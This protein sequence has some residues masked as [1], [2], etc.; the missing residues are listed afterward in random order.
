MTADA[1]PTATYRLQFGPQF[2]FADAAA[3]VPYL[4]ELGISHIYASPYLKARRGST[5]G[6]DIVDHGALNPQIG[7][8]SD[9]D[10]LV[11]QLH[12]HDMGQILD[13]VPNHMGVGGNDNAWWL[14]VL[15]NG[16][17]SP[18]AAYFDID[19]SPVQEQLRGKVLLP[20]LGNYYGDVL[21]N[22]ELQ[23]TFD[24]SA[25]TFS[26]HYHEHR[27]PL[28]PGTYPAVL[29][30]A[31][32]QLGSDDRNT[33]AAEELIGLIN[34]LEQLPP[35]R[36][37]DPVALSR[38][39]TDSSAGKTVL[40][41]LCAESPVIA[42]TVQRSCAALNGKP[43]HPGSFDALHDLLE[44]QAY[45][46]TY[47]QVARD[48]INYRRF[49]DINDLAALRTENPDVFEATHRYVLE[50]VAAG[51]ING[52][53]IDHPDGLY[54][55][56]RYYH[57]LQQRLQQ[58]R[59]GPSGTTG[60]AYILVEKILA[61]YE[62]LPDDW[63]VAGTTGYDFAHIVNGIYI[64][65]ASARAMGQLYS[66]FIGEKPDFDELLYDCKK[67][68]IH[69]QLSGELTVLSNLLHRI[70]QQDRHTR[71]FT[72]NGLRQALGEVVACFPVY[73]T[74]VTAEQV[75][76][77][78]R[79]Y[80]HWA[81]AQAKKRTPATDTATFDFIERMLTLENLARCSPGSR[82]PRIQFAMRLQQYTAPVTAKAMED[83]AFYIYNRLTGLNE[84]GGDP[85]SYGISLAA[86]H[87]ANQER[88]QRWPHALLS[89]STHDSKRSEDVRARLNVLSEIPQEWRRHVSRWSRLHRSRKRQLDGER[90]P[91][92][93]DEY[94]FY[95]TVLG[96][97]PMEPMDAVQIGKFRERIEQY[98]LKAIREA[99]THTSWI[100]PNGAYEEAVLQ[101]V[102]L[103]L[104]PTKKNA[105]IADLQV[106]LRR[107][108]HF[109]ALNSLSQLLLRLTAPGVPDLY[110]G[111][112]LWTFDLVDPDN[113][114]PVD[115]SRRAHLLHVLRS[116]DRPLPLQLAGLLDQLGDG[117]PKLYLAWRVLQFRRHH[118]A[119]FR[120][121]DY[122][123]LGTT[124]SHAENLCAF[125]RRH[126]R[127]LAVTVAPRWFT[128][129]TGVPSSIPL[130]EAA[131]GDTSI[132][133]DNDDAG[134]YRELLS[135]TKLATGDR[136]GVPTLRVADALA[137]FPV[138]LLLRTES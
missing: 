4:H 129:L 73:R 2:T 87:H 79:E 42:D 49:F 111:S 28:D 112:E 38:R 98:M 50:L 41:H 102:R 137:H 71:D 31:L 63:P 36:I 122:T 65:P 44:R 9:Y 77:R 10:R 32:E 127:D 13:I 59:G 108:E 46:L 114:R 91:S 52:L 68:I 86:F 88:A 110:Q 104:D 55:P 57:D 8:L 25:G 51:K 121:G 97:W 80:I 94:L 70:A 134:V 48:E 26:V 45:R 7:D 135:G 18:F 16:E 84:V 39:L 14:D 92:R 120:D 103:V 95:Q 37:S 90:A 40:A 133:L 34:M 107:L 75:G 30:L 76:D 22:G 53:R 124:G 69:T 99:K 72:L 123:A 82:V 119:L 89:G 61:T 21:D 130:G 54:D 67:L 116:D 23:L 62:H 11:E 136:S 33:A 85:R 27:F 29:R 125:A 5:H 74:Y 117:R 35:R 132:D 17:A 100:R 1:I 12:Q 20:F 81:V 96:A 118:P 56:A 113:R 109:G 105:F 60:D 58:A 83:T 115:Y 66:R 78:D 101:F 106:L 126:G 6:Y 19:W 93:N 47:W 3:I 15:E 24:R 138:A 64:Q 128:Q 131:W 43:S